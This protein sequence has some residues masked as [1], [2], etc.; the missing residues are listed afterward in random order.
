MYLA[1]RGK[2]LI[3]VI[4]WLFHYQAFQSNQVSPYVISS[5]VSIFF[6]TKAKA[7]E[8]NYLFC[9]CRV[10]LLILPHL[11]HILCSKRSFNDTGIIN[12]AFCGS[13]KF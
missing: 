13:I 11:L 10:K 6:V 9:I 8:T 12:K 1:V 4:S 7:K 5:C 3:D 2:C